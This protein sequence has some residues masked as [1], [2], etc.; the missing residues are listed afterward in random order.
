MH[1]FQRFFTKIDLNVVQFFCCERRGLNDL[2]VG[3]INDPLSA[4]VS[5][6]MMTR[7]VAES[8]LRV[9]TVGIDA[10][11]LFAQ[12]DFLFFL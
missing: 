9:L 1:A 7:G 11:I 4:L 6:E 10:E 5:I 2:Q 3:S 8:F 12:L